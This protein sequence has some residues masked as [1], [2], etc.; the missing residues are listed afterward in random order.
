MNNLQ[1]LRL[2]EVIQ[3]LPPELVHRFLK[4]YNTALKKRQ[5]SAALLPERFTLPSGKDSHQPAKTK[6]DQAIRAD[7]SFTNWRTET[8]KALQTSSHRLGRIIAT[9]EALASGQ[10]DFDKLADQNRKRLTTQAPSKRKPRRS[11]PPTDTPQHT[12]G[13]PVS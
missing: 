7:E 13:S 2:S 10:A 12:N 11:V 8:L 1:L 4:A 6:Q 3:D 5:I 9:F